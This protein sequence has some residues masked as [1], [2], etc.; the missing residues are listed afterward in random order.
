MARTAQGCMRR[1]AA[2]GLLVKSA[3]GVSAVSNGPAAQV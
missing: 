2:H 3:P 1:M